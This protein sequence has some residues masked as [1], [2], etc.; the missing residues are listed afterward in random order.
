MNAFLKERTRKGT[1]GQY[2]VEVETPIAETIPIIFEEQNLV[3]L[4]RTIKRDGSGM[5][6]CEKKI[7][8]IGL[9]RCWEY[10]KGGC[11]C[12]V[13]V[14]SK[15]IDLLNMSMQ[16]RDRSLPADYEEGEEIKEKKRQKIK[17]DYVVIA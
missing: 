17:R 10:Q 16:W 13:E 3:V 2:R 1:K 5:V 12:K 9:M 4:E 11:H 14:T 6:Y 7:S 8:H 15:E